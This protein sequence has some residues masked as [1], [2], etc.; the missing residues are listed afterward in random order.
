LRGLGWGLGL[1]LIKVRGK[2]RV[3]RGRRTGSGSATTST[4]RGGPSAPHRRLR[5][6]SRSSWASCRSALTAARYAVSGFGKPFKQAAVVRSCGTPRSTAAVTF[7]ERGTPRCSQR[8]MSSSASACLGV[9]LRASGFGL[10]ASG[11]GLRASGLGV[12]DWRL[13]L[14]AGLGLGSGLGLALPP[15]APRPAAARGAQG[16]RGDN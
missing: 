12:R 16:T 5:A 6:T 8:R 11:F 9:G 7:I 10:R 4:A 14:G 2:V 15:A 1:G 13:G 3:R